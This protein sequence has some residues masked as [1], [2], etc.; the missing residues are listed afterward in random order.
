MRSVR[1]VRFTDERQSRFGAECATDRQPLIH[2][3]GCRR[4]SR[5]LRRRMQSPPP[6]TAATWDPPAETA[7]REHRKRPSAAEHSPSEADSVR[8][9]SGDCRP[10]GR[11]SDAECARAAESAPDR[12]TRPSRSPRISLTARPRRLISS[13]ALT[14]AG[15]SA[16]PDSR[17]GAPAASVRRAR[18]SSRCGTPRTR[19]ESCR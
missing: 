16:C 11:Q 6:V 8:A 19:P 15:G 4:R 5:P 14:P 2:R 13:A 12:A 9:E 7:R 17:R 10:H 1:P 18:P 3:R